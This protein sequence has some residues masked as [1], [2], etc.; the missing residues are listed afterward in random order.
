MP[1]LF[2]DTYTQ[3]LEPMSEETIALLLSHCSKRKLPRKGIVF[4]AGDPADTL[5]YIVSGSV[6]VTAVDEDGSEIILAYLNEGEFI[7]EM[8][9]F[10][11][12][13]ARNALVRARMETELAEISYTK[14]NHLLK[15]ELSE[16][17]AI[18][19]R[20]I[21]FQLAQRLLKTSKRI[22]LLTS[23]DV[24]GRISRILLDMCYEPEAMSHPE[25][26]QIHISRQEIGRIINC[27]RETVGRVLKKMADE[28]MIE[29][30]G[31]NIVVYHSR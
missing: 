12:D 3:N 1:L 9:L 19:L 5:Y 14:L 16:H 4:R 7:G 11:T 15:T 30:K 29:V 17:H 23:T 10:I 25:G 24:S 20:T 13:I 31:M 26:T 22:S 27:S 28:G 2:N 6:S 21:S 8:G 18:I